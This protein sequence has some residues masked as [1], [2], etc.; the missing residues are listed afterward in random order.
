MSA[1]AKKVA[2]DLGVSRKELYETAM[3]VDAP[4]VGWARF[5]YYYFRYYMVRYIRHII[6]GGGGR[7]R[8]RIPNFP[9]QKWIS[10]I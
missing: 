1:A 8:I 10:I 6:Q 7:I 3:Q 5:V 4:C 9:H 2:K